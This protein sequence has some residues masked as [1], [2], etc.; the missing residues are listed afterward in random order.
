MLNLREKEGERYGGGGRIE[1][2]R[3]GE[4]QGGRYKI[5]EVK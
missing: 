5:M 4:E 1:Y 2:K 3:D